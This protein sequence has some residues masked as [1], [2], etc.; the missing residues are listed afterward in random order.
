MAIATRQPYPLQPIHDS[1][2]YRIWVATCKFVRTK[3]L[4][5]AGAV[6]ILVMALRRPLRRRHCP[7]RRL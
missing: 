6:V 2:S 1:T 7:I 3:P 5:A 4:G